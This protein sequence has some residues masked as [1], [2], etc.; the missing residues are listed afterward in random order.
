MTI[1]GAKMSAEESI[2]MSDYLAHQEAASEAEWL[3]R[4]AED[5]RESVSPAM[6]TMLVGIQSGAFKI[7]RTL[8]HKVLL[9]WYNRFYK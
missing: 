6:R 9:L 7:S 5:E 2:D 1:K 8:F 4:K 3:W